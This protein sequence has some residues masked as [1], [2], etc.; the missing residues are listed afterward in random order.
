[1]N[2]REVI[3]NPLPNPISAGPEPEADREIFLDGLADAESGEVEAPTGHFYRVFNRV[4]CTGEDGIGFTR[5]FLN[6]EDAIRFYD[7]L[8]EQYAHWLN[9]V[10][11]DD[12]HGAAVVEHAND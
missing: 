1:M 4:T 6:Y 11:P 3:S 7:A 9:E 12:Q 8:L 5:F 2:M 10:D